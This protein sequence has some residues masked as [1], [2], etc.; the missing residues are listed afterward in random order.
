MQKEEKKN[1]VDRIE[2]LDEYESMRKL[3]CPGHGTKLHPKTVTNG[4][5][6]M[7]QGKRHES[8]SVAKEFKNLHTASSAY[9]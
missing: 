4:S 1:D 8:P 6:S 7:S 3:N 9:C 2:G 5:D